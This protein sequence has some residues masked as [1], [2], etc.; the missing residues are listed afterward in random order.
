MRRGLETRT[1]SSSAYPDELAGWVDAL[2]SRHLG[3]LTFPELRKGV[4]ALSRLYV[5]SRERIGAGAALDG[6]GKRAAF[7][8]FYSPLHFLVVRE[9][10]TRLVSDPPGPRRI[11]DLGCGLAAASAAW[12]TSYAG[13]PT[14][15]GY[16]LS[17]WAVSEA[18]HTLHH[19]GLSGTIRRRSAADVPLAARGDA[20]VA[21]FAVNELSQKERSRLFGRL[22]QAGRRGA[23]VLVIEPIARSSAPWWDEWIEA[24]RSVGGRDD[25]WRF[26]VSLPPLLS[27]LDRASGLDHTE[28]TARSLFWGQSSTL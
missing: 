16:D 5:E 20:V 2:T 6:A 27:K 25:T 22:L 7:A 14:V 10:V 28:L 15:L 12:A 19:F 26:P 3:S 18:R 24:A 17:P 21:A 4:V 13:R 1:V 8:C 11:L 23:S 9:I